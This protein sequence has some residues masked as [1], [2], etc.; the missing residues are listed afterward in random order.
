MSQKNRKKELT[1]LENTKEA[2]SNSPD[3]DAV[4][5]I[6]KRAVEEGREALK[7]DVSTPNAIQ[8]A[9]IKQ[10]KLLRKIYGPSLPRQWS[11]ISNH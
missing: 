7:L 9:T 2:A 11:D 1:P 6:G 10:K 4:T 8:K 3:P 5:A